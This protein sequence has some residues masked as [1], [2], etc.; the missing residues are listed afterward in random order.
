M[1]SNLYWEQHK[2][3]V[4]AAIKVDCENINFSFNI[5]N[6]EIKKYRKILHAMQ[7]KKSYLHA[8]SNSRSSIRVN[9]D[10]IAF[11]ISFRSVEIQKTTFNS[12]S[13]EPAIIE[14]IRQL[15]AY[16]SIESTRTLV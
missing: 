12:K 9:G 5:D 8:P 15:S 4:Y 14:L 16:S 6:F 1:I 11:I 13:L 3:Y 10:K 2:D 7:N